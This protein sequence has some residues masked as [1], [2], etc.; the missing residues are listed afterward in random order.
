MYY[1]LKTRTRFFCVLIPVKWDRTV[2]FRYYKHCTKLNFY[3]P[4]PKNSLVT[5]FTP[6]CFAQQL[7]V[8]ITDV[9]NYHVLGTWLSYGQVEFNF[10]SIRRQS[11]LKWRL[12]FLAQIFEQISS[13]NTETVEILTLTLFLEACHMVGLNFNKFY[14]NFLLNV[15]FAYFIYSH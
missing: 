3:T 5:Y 13:K 12:C 11:P 10:V 14:I 1:Y 7:H 15:V 4:A 9:W 6:V 2:C 8:L